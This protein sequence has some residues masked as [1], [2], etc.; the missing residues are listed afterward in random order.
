MKRRMLKRLKIG[1]ITSRAIKQIRYAQ[2]HFEGF[3][4]KIN[5]VGCECCGYQTDGFGD[6]C[7][8]CGWE[9]VGTELKT[10]A[11]PICLSNYQ[12]L[13]YIYG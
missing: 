11:N 10:G 2:K 9:Q 4:Y 1:K 5:S 12:E 13:Y 8:R 3:E 7:N 6:I